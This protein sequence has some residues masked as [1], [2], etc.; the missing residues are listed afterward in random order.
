MSGWIGQHGQLNGSI[1]K[2]GFSFTGVDLMNQFG[3]FFVET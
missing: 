2:F 3:Q 1:L